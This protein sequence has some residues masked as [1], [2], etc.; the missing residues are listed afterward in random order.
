MREF[1]YGI[2]CNFVDIVAF[3]TTPL[4]GVY[5]NAAVHGISAIC[6]EKYRPIRASMSAEVDGS[7]V[8]HFV[9]VNSRPS[10]D[11]YINNPVIVSGSQFCD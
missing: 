3:N 7:G 10:A 1:E 8:F 9:P 5:T 11:V 6:S 4:V 2:I